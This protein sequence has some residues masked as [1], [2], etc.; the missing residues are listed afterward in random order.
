MTTKTVYKTTRTFTD[1]SYV[2]EGEYDTPESA[3][4]YVRGCLAQGDTSKIVVEA[5]EVETPLLEHYEAQEAIIEFFKPGG[6]FDKT[7]TYGEDLDAVLEII[8]RT[9]GYTEKIGD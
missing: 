1:P 2:S 8:K 9:K 5:V 3:A 4:S 7:D 6:G